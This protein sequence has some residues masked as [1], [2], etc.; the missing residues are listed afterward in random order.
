TGAA[1][2]FGD[3][4]P[5]ALLYALFGVV[6]LFAVGLYS[7]RQRSTS[8]GIMVRILA[9]DLNA[10][11]LSALVY[12]FLPDIAVGRGL[13]GLTGILGA[14]V[15]ATVRL[16]FERVV[17]ENLFKRRVL[18]YGAGKRAAS[19]L[20]LRRR[21]DMRGFQIVAFVAAEG[22]HV[23]AGED[24]LT[25]RPDDLFRWS[26]DNQVDEIVVAMDDR[27]RNFPMHEFLE[28]RLAGVDVLELPTFLERETGKVRLDV[29]SPSWIIFGGGFRAS[30]LQRVLERGFDILASLGL[31][32]VALPFMLLAVLA[33]WLEDGWRAPVLYRQRRVGRYGKSFD[34][35]KFRSMSVDAEQG[36]AI[37]AVE[38]DPRVTKVGSIMRKTRIDE[39]PQ[40]LNVLRGEMSFVGPRPERPEFVE[41]LE[42]KIPY[43]RERHTVKPGIT[44]WAQLCYPYGSTEKD[45]LEKLQYDLYYVKN[46]SLLFDLAILVQTV[47]VVLWGK[48]AR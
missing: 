14:L 17:D 20:E 27:R 46:R 44:G 45:A 32:A 29:L 38:N 37:W 18:V 7:T 47:E 11:G 39:L 24:R 15:L 2:A 1:T 13:L 21:S 31:L 48:G 12:Y 40:L 36:E 28:C 26:I 9:A 41:R 16:L 3:L 43:Y 19:L 8:A 6:S 22:D 10:V 5:A 42:Q 34:V 30:P 33:I 4:L 35:L 25:E 23:T